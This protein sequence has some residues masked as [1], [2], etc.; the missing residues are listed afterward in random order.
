MVRS[1]LIYVS[2]IHGVSEE[3]RSSGEV[4]GVLGGNSLRI[5]ISPYLNELLDTPTLFSLRYLRGKVF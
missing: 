1:E 5:S 2:V 3:T 4:L